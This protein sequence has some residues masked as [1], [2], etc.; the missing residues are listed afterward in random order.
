MA[1]IKMTAPATKVGGIT[2]QTVLV[3]PCT[4]ETGL[5]IMKSAK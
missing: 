3:L 5:G 4:H 2:W 1:A